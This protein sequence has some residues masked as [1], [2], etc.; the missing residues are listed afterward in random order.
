MAELCEISRSRWYELVEAGVFPAPVVLLPIKRPVYDRSLIEKCLQIK[1][2]GIGLSG[3]PVVFNRKRKW[4]WQT[5]QKA[6]PVA[7][8]KP[9]DSLMEPILD[10]VKALGLTTTLQAV[11]D[12]V[13]ALYPTGI[14]GQDQ[15]DV[16]RKTF[17]F[18]Q[19]KR[20]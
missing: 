9:L 12:A 15:G 19:G 16:I 6:K 8:E 10:S 2:T 4:A 1:Q 18:L 5:K 20:P 3:S 13:A 7:K 14:A 11:T 17:L